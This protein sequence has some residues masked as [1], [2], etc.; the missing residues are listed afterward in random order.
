MR[1]VVL[2][3]FAMMLS[4]NIFTQNSYRFNYQ[5]V[6]RDASGAVLTEQDVSVRIALLRDSPDGTQVFQ[7]THQTQTN[8]FGLVHL[9]IGSISSLQDIN[10]GD[11]TWFIQISV[12]NQIMGV[13]QVL[14]VPYA[15]HAFTSADRFS[16]DYQDLNNTPDLSGFL[17]QE[18]D[19]F[20]A[21]SAAASILQEQINRWEEA[22]NWGDHS[23]M[24]Y[25]LI[26]DPLPGDMA[27]YDGDQWQKIPSGETHQ[28]LTFCYGRPQWGPC[29]AIAEVV[30][31]EISNIT[32]NTAT[33]G[34]EVVSE[35][36]ATVSARGVCWSTAP[37]P[38]ISDSYT[39]DGAG[40]GMF[41]SEIT[42]L[43]PGTTYFVR[44]YATNLYS[45]A[46]G[47]EISFTTS[48]P[49]VELPV[50]DFNGPL[51][52]HP[53]DNASATRYGPIN[54]L[55]EANSETDGQANTI[56]I[57]SALGDYNNGNYAAKI[58]QDLEAFGY[59]DWY[60]PSKDELNAIYLNQEQ[61]GGF[62]GAGYWTSTEAT[63]VNAFNQYFHTGFSGTS[64]KTNN[65]RLRCV[66]RN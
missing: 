15:L 1:K 20:F 43:Q 58:C 14:S 56:A 26:E 29:P 59:T 57:V 31:S 66:R 39:N 60:L 36:D 61:V 44:A 13:S 5:A 9:E 4:L 35:G 22:H 3:I 50:V 18:T 21:E 64:V 24:G 12:N 27:W 54:I 62:S 34:G 53:E 23:E 32:M 52:V 19:P 48:S 38:T 2:L 16:G 46:Y 40:P 65:F 45:T 63:T 42:G 10:W 47:E 11:H 7:E 33:G 17:L 30:T 37:N 25:T 51:Y 55:I 6:L 41:V 49:G 8:A 28:T